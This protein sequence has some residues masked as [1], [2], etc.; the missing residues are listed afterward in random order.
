MLDAA[1]VDVT[2]GEN[3]FLPLAEVLANNGDDAHIGKEAGGE[4]K[5][6]CR[7]AQTAFALARRGFDGVIC[8]AADYGNGHGCLSN[9][10]FSAHDRACADLAVMEIHFCNLR[11]LE[12]KPALILV[13]FTARLKPCR[14]KKLI[15]AND[16]RC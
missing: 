11:S 3:C 5:V 6:R 12:L 1:G 10:N 9:S 16:A 7:A 8:Y 2:G 13:P 14:K 15:S 4:R